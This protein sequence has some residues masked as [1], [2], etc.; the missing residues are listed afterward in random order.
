MIEF[1]SEVTG[2]AQVAA[3]LRAAPSKVKQAV[4]RAVNMSAADVL[5]GAKAKVS[6]DVL[7][8]RSGRLRRSLHFTPGGDETNPEAS[9]GTNVEY[10]AI[11]EFGGTTKPHIIEAV[12]GKTLAFMGKGGK[13]VFRALV[14]HPG[15]VMP[16]RSF[17]RSALAERADSVKQRIADAVGEGIA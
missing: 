15:S 4:R 13:M 9:V 10:A 7:N 6:D 3:R 17:L 5:E 2:D 1:T 8:V 16:E 11:H 14:H 12:N